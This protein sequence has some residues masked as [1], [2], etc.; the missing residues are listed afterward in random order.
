VR[1]LW[2]LSPLGDDAIIVLSDDGSVVAGVGVVV[3]GLLHDWL[4]W[5]ISLS[6]AVG[7]GC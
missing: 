5:L 6:I 4:K 2:R 3:V 7:S 1:F